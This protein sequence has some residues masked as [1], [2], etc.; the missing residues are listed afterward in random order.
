M[1]RS[2]VTLEIAQENCSSSKA[3]KAAKLAKKDD[4]L[5]NGNSFMQMGEPLSVY[6]SSLDQLPLSEQMTRYLAQQRIFSLGKVE[7]EVKSQ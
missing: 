4:V 6:D 1:Q 2:N 5:E 7:A 3:A